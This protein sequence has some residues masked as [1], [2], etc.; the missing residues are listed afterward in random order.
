VRRDLAIVACAIA[1]GVAVAG[2]RLI[3]AAFL[4]A[5]SVALTLKGRGERP[6]PLGLTALIAA[7]SATTALA[8]SGGHD[9]KS[10]TDH[11][12]HHTQH[13]QVR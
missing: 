10:R 4:G 8:F 3:V 2:H 1:A 5:A 7:F 9:L 13:V 11:H 6:I 12:I